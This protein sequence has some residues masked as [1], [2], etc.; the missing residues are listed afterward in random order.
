MMEHH[1]RSAGE[2]A[3][4]P[5]TQPRLVMALQARYV[6]FMTIFLGRR[7]A[8]GPAIWLG[9]GLSLVFWALLLAGLVHLFRHGF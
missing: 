2:E 7:V 8:P 6:T 3:S 5:G 9:I 4:K 1:G